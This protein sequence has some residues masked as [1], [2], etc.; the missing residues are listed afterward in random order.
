MPRG[1]AAEHGELRATIGRL[2]RERFVDD[3][4]GELLEAGDPRDDVEA[5]AVKGRSPRLVR[6]SSRGG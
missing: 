4:V 5:D 3:R 2:A 1:A 6:P